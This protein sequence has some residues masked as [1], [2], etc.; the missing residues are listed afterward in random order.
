MTLQMSVNSYDL[1]HLLVLSY[2]PYSVTMKAINLKQLLHPLQL[3]HMG[4]TLVR[5]VVRLRNLSKLSPESLMR[6]V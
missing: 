1:K 6:F 3:H 5:T 2:C 4:S